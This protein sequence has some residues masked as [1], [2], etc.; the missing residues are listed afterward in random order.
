MLPPGEG[1]PPYDLFSVNGRRDMNSGNGNPSARRNSDNVEITVSLPD[2]EGPPPYDFIPPR[3]IANIEC[4]P[5]LEGA[6]SAT[7]DISSEQEI[8]PPDS[9][10][11]PPPY[12]AVPTHESQ[13]SQSLLSSHNSLSSHRN[14]HSHHACGNQTNFRLAVI[15]QENSPPRLSRDYDPQEGTSAC[16]SKPQG[17]NAKRLPHG[18]NRGRHRKSDDVEWYHYSSVIWTPR[19]IANIECNPPLEAFNYCCQ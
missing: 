6:T 4:N 8:L 3:G 19:G 18:T 17:G 15:S 10:E 7:H 11:A 16:Y 5:P 1:P 2:E 9:E 14:R 13:I 12:S